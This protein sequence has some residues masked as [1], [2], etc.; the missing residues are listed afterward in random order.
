VVFVDTPEKLFLFL[1]LS[2]FLLSPACAV[3]I[4][5]N[6]LN[7]ASNQ[8]IAIYNPTLP[9]NES[10]IGTYNATDSV[11]LPDGGAYVAVLRPGPQHWFDNPLNAIELFKLS[12]PPAMAF[13]LFFV[14]IV[15]SIAVVFRIFK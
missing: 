15:G 10:L 12:I 3:S 4:T 7:L 14:V 2:S 8:Q 9:A 11:I 13:L 6:D 1:L 5:F